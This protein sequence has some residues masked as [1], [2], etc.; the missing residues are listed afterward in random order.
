MTLLEA[1]AFVLLPVALP[2]LGWIAVRRYERS[3]DRQIASDAAAA[4]QPSMPAASRPPSGS[5]AHP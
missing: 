5:L 1:F 3:L 2:V 4:G